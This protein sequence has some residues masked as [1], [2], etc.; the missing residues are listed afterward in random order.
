MWMLSSWEIKKDG[1]T[2]DPA[3]RQAK[4][5]GELSAESSFRLSRVGG[6][7]LGILNSRR[8]Q[9]VVIRIDWESSWS[10]D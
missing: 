3:C 7:I 2:M 10:V 8:E 6:N 1:L 5:W 9:L 4:Q